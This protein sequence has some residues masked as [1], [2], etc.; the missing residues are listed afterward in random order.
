MD[1]GYYLLGMTNL[2]PDVFKNK[3][4]GTKTVYK[5]TVKDLQ[6]KKVFTLETL[7]DIDFLEDLKPYKQFEHLF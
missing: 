7:N 6:H 5:D 2:I 1:G 3:N 4:W